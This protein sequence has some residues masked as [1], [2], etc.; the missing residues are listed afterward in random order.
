MPSQRIPVSSSV[1]RTLLVKQRQIIAQIA[2]ATC[3]HSHYAVINFGTILLA[4]EKAIAR[5]FEASVDAVMAMLIVEAH[6][7]YAILASIDWIAEKRISVLTRLL[8]G[9]TWNQACRF[10]DSICTLDARAFPLTAQALTHYQ[11]AREK[12]KVK[13]DAFLAEDFDLDCFPI[14][15]LCGRNSS[16]Q[17]QCRDL[18][19]DRV[20]F[21]RPS[22]SFTSVC[23]FCIGVIDSLLLFYNSYTNVAKE[24]NAKR[25][26][27]VVPVR[28]VRAKDLGDIVE[29]VFSKETQLKLC[30]SIIAFRFAEADDKALF[31]SALLQTQD[32]LCVEERAL[33]GLP[34]IIAKAYYELIAV[35]RVP[36]CTL[37]VFREGGWSE[38]GGPRLSMIITGTAEMLLV[39]PKTSKAI[40]AFDRAVEVKRES[41]RVISITQPTKKPWRVRFAS[42]RDAV[43][44]VAALI[45]HSHAIKYAKHT[46]SAVAQYVESDQQ[47]LKRC[48]DVGF[49]EATERRAA[50]IIPH[51][52]FHLSPLHLAMQLKDCRFLVIQCDSEAAC[53]SLHSKLAW[54]ITKESSGS[55]LGL[56]KLVIKDAIEFL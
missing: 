54:S 17:W 43:A 46:E 13:L 44:S 29:V 10:I 23:T 16:F 38:V 34:P 1:W 30:S 4:Y 56:E 24:K 45:Y 37:F 41:E 47:K 26:C 35:H 42:A 7:E 50:F 48:P 11:E 2:A 19:V 8:Y 9:C 25:K 53:R 36:V 51:S 6:E 12:R 28:F 33:V 40:Y 20:V 21:N 32:N 15:P 27:I 55:M 14:L 39:D 5:L 52:I 49:V 18:V 31:L 22:K 3:A